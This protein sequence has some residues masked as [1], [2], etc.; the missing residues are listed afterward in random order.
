VIKEVWKGL[1]RKRTGVMVKIV[2]ESAYGNVGGD[3]ES[4]GVMDANKEDG[5]VEHWR[6]FDHSPKGNLSRRTPGCRS[7]TC[8]E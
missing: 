1:S 6:I 8:V 5:Y 7:D 2:N 3:L 4:N